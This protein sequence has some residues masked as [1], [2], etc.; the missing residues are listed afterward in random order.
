MKPLNEIMAV[1]KD[2]PTPKK[3][4]RLRY[5]IEQVETEGVPLGAILE[6]Y[7]ASV[8]DFLANIVLDLADDL[9]AIPDRKTADVELKESLDLIRTIAVYKALE[10]QE[11]E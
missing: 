2:M 9:G 6:E 4:E 1:T 3:I 10:Q 5:E 7:V 11:Q 8:A